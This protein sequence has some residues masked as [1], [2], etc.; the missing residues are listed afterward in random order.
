[1]LFPN[2]PRVLFFSGKSVTEFLQRFSDI[3]INYR[4]VII[5]DKFN[6]LLRYYEKEIKS[7]IKLI[8]EY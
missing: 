2:I 8:V 7:F 3:Y 1:M 5:E 4:V 6:K